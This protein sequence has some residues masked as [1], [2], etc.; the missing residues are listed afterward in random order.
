MTDSDIHVRT[1]QGRLPL[2]DVVG[3]VDH[4]TVITLAY[5]M[6]GRNCQGSN[7]EVIREVRADRTAVSTYQESI[8]RAATR[9]GI[10][11]GL[12]YSVINYYCERN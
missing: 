8:K 9:F 3:T 12:S 1:D 11:D 7:A 2:G 6:Y 5:N 10:P 4:F